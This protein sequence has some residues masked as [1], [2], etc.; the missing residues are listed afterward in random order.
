MWRCCTTRISLRVARRPRGTAVLGNA[1]LAA[2]TGTA[3]SA[4][5]GGAIVTLSYGHL[6]W[7][8]AMLSWIP[9]LLVLGLTEPQRGPGPREEMGGRAHGDT[10]G[11]AGTRHRDAARVP[12]QGRLGDRRAGDVLGEPEILA[13]ERCAPGLFR[14]PPGW[15]RFHLRS[16]REGRPSRE[17]EIRPATVARRGWRVAHRRVFRDGVCPRLDR[18]IDRD[19]GP[20][21]PGPGRRAFPRGAQREDLLRVPRDRDLHGGIWGSAAPSVSWALSWA[22]ESTAWDS[23]PS[24][25]RSE[26]CSRSRSC[27]CSCRWSCGEWL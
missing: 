18:D 3:V 15:L 7:A 25:R 5:V 19:P 2:Q 11:H 21:G 22:M 20:G 14:S 8:N 23:R 24:C 9:V 26:S 17:D 27:S 6:L 10:L 1:R 16:R 4:L 12:Q 13:G